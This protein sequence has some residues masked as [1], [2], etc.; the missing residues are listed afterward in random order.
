[1]S[2]LFAVAKNASHA[3]GVYI[4]RTGR[5]PI[6]VGKAADIRKRLSSYF[7]KNVSSK[8]RQLIEEATALD[9]IVTESEIGA[10]ILE[11]EYIKRHLPKFN[12]LMRDD[13]NYFYVAITREQ[14]PRIFLTHQLYTGITRGRRSETGKKKPPVSSSR[15]PASSFI[16]P[17][18]SGTALKTVLGL[19]RRAFPYCT[20]T[21]MHKRPCLNSQIGRCLGFCCNKNNVQNPNEKLQKEYG[22]NI[23]NIIAILTG[24]KRKLLSELKR[25]MHDAAKKEDFELAA[26]LRNQ[27]M[28]IENIFSHRW[29]A[30]QERTHPKQILNWKKIERVIQTLLNTSSP[31]SRVEG[32]DISNVSGTEAT[33]SMVVFI[34][35]R[36]VKS[37]YRKFKIKTVSG[38]NDVAMHREV[39]Q[40]RLART[41]WQRPDLLLIDGGKPQLNAVRK[42]LRPG[43]PDIP[44]AALAKREE[45]L[46]VDGRPMPQRLDSLP[47]EAKFF[48]QH[49]RDESHRFAKKYHHKLREMALRPLLK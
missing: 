14:F 20:C 32:Y 4:F 15:S 31:I 5:K 6:Y 17:F 48:F 25:R 3:P 41:D 35:G 2:I 19:L 8:T 9:W 45:E 40:R 39:M 37:E 24:K 27:M 49:V 22:V 30:R 33:G 34:D 47:P 26:K 42:E 44:L 1:M 43:N 18:T 13:K 7:R 29:I 46:F 28:S 36:P 12:V 38:P 21:Q 16:G 23:K 11:A 10:L